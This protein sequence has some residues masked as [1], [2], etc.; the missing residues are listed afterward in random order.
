MRSPRANHI[1]SRY[2]VAKKC[3]GPPNQKGSHCFRS[4]GSL[5]S[6]RS[7]SQTQRKIFGFAKRASEIRNP[8][9]PKNVCLHGL[10]RFERDALKMSPL[11]HQNCPLRRFGA[12]ELIPVVTDAGPTELQYFQPLGITA[13]A[14]ALIRRSSLN[15]PRL[16]R[17]KYSE[18]LNG[19]LPASRTS[20]TKL[21]GPFRKSTG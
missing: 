20:D 17:K 1:R 11:Q 6:E 10:S 14:R 4:A 15:P 19:S 2:L 21:P 12:T 9:R 5:R 7:N 18:L 16:A 8:M 3:G 13:D